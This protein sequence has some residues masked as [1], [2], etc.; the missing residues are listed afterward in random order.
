M[1]LTESQWQTL[2]EGRKQQL[3][4]TGSAYVLD[5]VKLCRRRFLP[6][7]D[8]EL[9]PF[10]IRRLHRPEMRS[11]MM[12]NPPFSVN[13]FFIEV[14][15]LEDIVDSLAGS[16]E[17]EDVKKT[18]NDSLFQAVEALTNQVAILTR[19]AVRPVS[20]GLSKPAIK[21]VS[22]KRRPPRSGEE[23]QCYNYNDFGHFSRDCTRSNLRWNRPRP[24]NESADS[25]G[26]SRP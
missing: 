13:D 17:K 18:A 12:G 24:E 7:T 25:S 22:F 16:T 6:L 21:Q 23:I 8:V 5:K 4:Q 15:R 3:N 26:Q 11:V 19:A 9:I 1:Q 2:V 10:L 14:R 20:L